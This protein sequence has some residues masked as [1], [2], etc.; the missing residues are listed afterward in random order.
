M[1]NKLN[2][3]GRELLVSLA[4]YRL[5]TVSQIAALCA[6]GKPAARNRVGKLTNA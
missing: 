1:T 2:T 6:V 4:E 5:L 3:N